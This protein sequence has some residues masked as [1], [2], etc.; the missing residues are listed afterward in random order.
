M[1]PSVSMI[2]PAKLSEPKAKEDIM[3]WIETVEPV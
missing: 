2:H 3:C 1:A